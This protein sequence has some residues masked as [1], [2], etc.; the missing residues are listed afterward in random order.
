MCASPGAVGIMRE[1]WTRAGVDAPPPPP[2]FV[3]VHGGVLIATSTPTPYVN[4]CLPP[5]STQVKG[6]QTQAP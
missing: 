1:E 6:S 3:Q 2:V 4:I 5:G